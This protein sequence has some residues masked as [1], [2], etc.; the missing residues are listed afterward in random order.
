MVKRYLFIICILSMSLTLS[1]GM[2]DSKPNFW[3][4]IHLPG[5]EDSVQI[6]MME[7]E[8]TWSA[9]S[10]LIA[11][12]GKAKTKFHLSEPVQM[13]VMGMRQ[14]ALPIVRNL[15]SDWIDYSPKYPDSSRA[16]IWYPADRMDMTKPDGN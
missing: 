2:K 10:L 15:R 14:L 5:I 11:R 6:R 4:T 3:L 13:V 1:A 8:N 9:P 7:K 16:F 12:H